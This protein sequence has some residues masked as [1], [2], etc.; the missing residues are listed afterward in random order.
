VAEPVIRRPGDS[1]PLASAVGG[2]VTFAVRGDETGGHLTVLE[3][4]APP[5]EGPPFHTH[6][7][8]DECL[9]VLEGTMRFRLRDEIEPAPA[10]SFVYVPRGV[11]HTWQNLGAEQ[12]R[13]LV[14]FAPAGM[15]RFFD[16]FAALAA[17]PG[18]DAFAQAAAG[19][20]MEAVG[21]PLGVSHP[22]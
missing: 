13:M 10:G 20:G 21:P 5:G 11:P 6:A 8:E 12:A 9:F 22:R 17:Q 16:R 18:P 1:I 7:N 3:I 14:L 2:E 19:S 15:E 4:V